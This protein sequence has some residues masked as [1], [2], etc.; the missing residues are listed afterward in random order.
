MPPT[1]KDGQEVP[2]AVRLRHRSIS[3]AMNAG[4]DY[5]DEEWEFI[6]ALDEYKKRYKKPFPSW[7]ETLALIR[8]LGYR[9]VA[10]PGPP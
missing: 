1:R 5:S 10:P 7:S 9:K 3:N 2:V 6:K 4:A 8:A